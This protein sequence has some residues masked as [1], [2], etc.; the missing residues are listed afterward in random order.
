MS[1]SSNTS[2]AGAVSASFSQSASALNSISVSATSSSTN[3]A[4]N[5]PAMQSIND[6]QQGLKGLSN[7][8]VSAGNNIHSIA[9]EFDK[10][11]QNIAQLTKFNLP[12]GLR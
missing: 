11:D 1:I 2:I 7:S 9:K 10:V 8:I 3:V 4:G 6:F 12:G 5:T